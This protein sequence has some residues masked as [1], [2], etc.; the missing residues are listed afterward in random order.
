[1]T[2][3][4]WIYFL[5]FCNSLCP[6]LLEH[7]ICCC[8]HV[9]KYNSLTVFNVLRDWYAWG[10]PAEPPDIAK[11]TCRDIF[12]ASADGCQ[13]DKMKKIACVILQLSGLGWGRFS[14]QSHA[15]CQHFF[16]SLQSTENRTN[17]NTEHNHQIRHQHVPVCPRLVYVLW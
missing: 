16:L 2:D 1:M 17:P 11:N 7:F 15:A 3:I 12:T 10:A 4:N 5:R 8:Q 9:L 6:L 13:V 14:P